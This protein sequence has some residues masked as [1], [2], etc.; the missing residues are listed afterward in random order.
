[1]NLAVRANTMID[2]ISPTIC[3]TALG[4]AVRWS[5][6]LAVMA[7]A[8]RG[9]FNAVPS[10]TGG[11]GS[12]NGSTRIAAITSRTASDLLYFSIRKRR[13]P[14]VGHRSRRGLVARCWSSLVKEISGKHH[15]SRLR[16]TV[17]LRAPMCCWLPW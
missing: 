1:M 9:P 17:Y 8:Q 11:H 4:G 10:Q 2:T 15:A 3:R 14:P 5:L 7:G 6:R 13:R 16:R 12:R